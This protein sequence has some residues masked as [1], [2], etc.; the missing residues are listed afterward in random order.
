M[1]DVAHVTKIDSSI[2]PNRA[3]LLSCAVSTGNSEQI[4]L[5]SDTV[6]S[7]DAAFT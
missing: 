5:L 7:R 4:F 2:P 1:V 3:C 6:T